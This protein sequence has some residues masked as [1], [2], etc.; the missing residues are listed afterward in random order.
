MHALVSASPAR[1][2]PGGARSGGGDSLW[3]SRPRFSILFLVAILTRCGMSVSL[4]VHMWVS[5]LCCECLFVGMFR[6]VV[7]GM[8]KWVV[9]VGLLCCECWNLVV[10]L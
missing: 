9:L 3:F 5:E 6:I 7:L 4:C 2:W 8:L 1:E 10:V